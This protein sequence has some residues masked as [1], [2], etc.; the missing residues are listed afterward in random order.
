MKRMNDPPL[1]YN[2][3]MWF[4]QWT[5]RG[6]FSLFL[7]AV[8]NLGCAAHHHRVGTGQ[9]GVGQSSMRQYY[10]F[11]GLLR[12]NEVDTQRLSG[13]LTSYEIV[14]ERSFSDFLV[15][16]LLLPL[17]VTSRTVTVYR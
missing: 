5:V 12:L 4:G 13:N 11:F 16:P 17:T 7:A 9:N 1:M 6:F 10:L 8:L 15:M 14:T 2:P 3:R